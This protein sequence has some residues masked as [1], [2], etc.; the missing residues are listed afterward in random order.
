MINI[1]DWDMKLWLSAFQSFLFKQK[2]Q[3]MFKMMS[4]HNGRSVSIFILFS[5]MIM[6]NF[7]MSFANEN[8]ETDKGVIQAG[9]E[10]AK[11]LGLNPIPAY[12]N[13]NGEIIVVKGTV[14]TIKN[15]GIVLTNGDMLINAGNRP[16]STGGCVLHKGEYAIVEGEVIKK[17]QD[18]LLTIVGASPSTQAEIALKKDNKY[19]PGQNRRNVIKGT[20]VNFEKAKEYLLPNSHLQL[21]YAGPLNQKG[22]MVA[23]MK[24]SKRDGYL[25]FISDLPKSKLE[26]DGRFEIEFDAL[27]PGKYNIA[28]QG[29]KHVFRAGSFA[30]QMQ[31]F[32]STDAQKPI[33]YELEISGTED[34][35]RTVNVDKVY[36]SII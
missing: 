29:I 35:I 34:K 23:E 20:I 7:S 10:K 11:L 32:L 2:G 27:K 24:I 31:F 28:V 33:W 6:L 21:F 25:Y 3:K 5:I 1:V 26:Q 15:G 18:N 12:V 9:K 4:I 22:Q 13:A 17:T 30:K 8:N 36:F 19:I 14:F 16:L